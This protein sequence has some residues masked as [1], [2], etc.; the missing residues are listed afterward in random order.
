LNTGFF[1]TPVFLNEANLQY[2]QNGWTF[3]ALGV[4]VNIPD[5]DK[6]N[7]AFANNTPLL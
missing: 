5:A 6:I 3:K 1:G 7:A 2:R 4:I